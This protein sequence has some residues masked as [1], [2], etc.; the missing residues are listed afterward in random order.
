MCYKVE[1]LLNFSIKS[2]SFSILFVNTP[3][4]RWCFALCF[5]V[6]K[7]FTEPFSSPRLCVAQTRLY[8]N[9]FR[10]LP[11]DV[12]IYAFGSKAKIFAPNP[13]IPLTHLRVAQVLAT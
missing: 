6:C 2:R 3:L 8:S 5:A 10:F 1:I 9:Y 11:L 12:C 7:T 13:P 4:A